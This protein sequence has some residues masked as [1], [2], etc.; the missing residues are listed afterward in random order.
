MRRPSFPICAGSFHRFQ[1]VIS[2]NELTK[3]NMMSIKPGSSSKSNEKLWSVCI[4]T[5]ICHR[6]H[7]SLLVLKLQSWCF[8]CKLFTIYWSSSGSIMAGEI[9]ALGH[10]SLYYSVESWSWKCIFFLIV[11]CTEW[12]E[13]LCCFWSMILVKFKY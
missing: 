9:S 7:S 1:N 4:W 3:N 11:S 13:I 6:K 8:I 10:K 2:F 5:C 12:S